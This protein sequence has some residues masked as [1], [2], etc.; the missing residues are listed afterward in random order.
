MK[1]ISITLF[2]FLFTTD[3]SAEAL[4]GKLSGTTYTDTNGIFTTTLPSLDGELKDFPNAVSVYYSLTGSQ[5]SLE[6]YP[7]P[8]NELKKFD[9][10]GPK[11]YHSQFINKS[12]ID[13]RYRETFKNVNI[14]SEHLET[15]HDTSMYIT[16]LELPNG[17][18]ITDGKNVKQDLWV[19]LGSM[20]Q[21]KNIFLYQIAVTDISNK[22]N[23]EITKNMSRKIIQWANN[24]AF[25]KT[26]I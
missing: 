23:I 19:T 24:T 21:G 18:A 14:V 12:I 7:V 13:K 11:T 4:L 15:I 26:N 20:I 2:I 17:S 8:E 10:L 16:V 25:N 1:I 5:D 22:N 9:V 3:V 6:Y